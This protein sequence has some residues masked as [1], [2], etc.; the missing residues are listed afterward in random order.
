VE[1]YLRTERLV[2]RRFTA[3]DVDLLVELDSDPAVMHF[4]TGGEP[5]S[6]QEIVDDVLP[7]FLSYYD[8][9]AGFGFWAALDAASGEF[10]GWFHLRP[11]PEDPPDVVELGYRLRRAAWGRGYATEGSRALIAK[12]FTDL[13]VRRVHAET[14]A[15][16]DASRAVMERAGLHHVRTFHQP[17]P[18]P[19]PGDEFGDVEY[20][21]TVQEW[22]DASGAR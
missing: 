22:Q 6:R 10:L 5:T 21:V 7:A 12:A 8:R 16:H 2:L 15:V 3:D 19:I 9:F 11:A 4:V 17:W 13:G 18:Y 1:E 20:A 14:M